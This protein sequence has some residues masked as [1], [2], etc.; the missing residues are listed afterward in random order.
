[1]DQGRERDRGRE[2]SKEGDYRGIEGGRDRSREGRGHAGEG[3]IEEGG[4][5][6]RSR[7]GIR[8]DRG[9]IE[10]WGSR[11]GGMGI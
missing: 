3:S 6:D 5:R 11:E 9:G 8:R 7:E 10:E 2:G 1:M 4:G